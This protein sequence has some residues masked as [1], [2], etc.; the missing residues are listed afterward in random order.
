MMPVHNCVVDRLLGDIAHGVD[1]ILIELT[2]SNEIDALTKE[3]RDLLL[4][5]W[6]AASR[7]AIVEAIR[8]LTQLSGEI[9]KDDVALV[10]STLEERLGQTLPAAIKNDV[11]DLTDRIY[12]TGKSEVV[13]Q[14]GVKLSFGVV[15]R[16]T[17]NSLSR[18][19]VYWVGQYWNNQVS[20]E[21]KQ[22]LADALEQGLSREEAAALLDEKFGPL[23]DKSM[24][25]WEGFANQTVTRARE[26]GHTEAYVNG[27]IEYLE[28]RAVIDSRTTEICLRMHG[29]MIPVANAVKLRD[30]MI[31]AKDPKDVMQIAP[32]VQGDEIKG[33]KSSKLPTGLALP[34]Y[35][36]NCR[37]TTVA[38]F[39]KPTEPDRLN[40]TQIEEKLPQ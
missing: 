40:E 13:D 3:L 9:S 34:P 1:G 28:V 16:K 6:S 26:F 24:S 32:W 39:G 7:D 19:S 4:Q 17:I 18:Q 27:G 38:V 14:I 22:T 12:S 35:H 8:Q 11:T 29:R 36:F 33:K 10:I 23:V 20:D 37:T 15:D 25:Y 21:I 5:K 31:N 2:K 30:A